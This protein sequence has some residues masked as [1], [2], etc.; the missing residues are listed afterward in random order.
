M[1][2]NAATACRTSGAQR[3]DRLPPTPGKQRSFVAQTCNDLV[4]RQR[5]VDLS[6]RGVEILDFDE[7]ALRGSIAKL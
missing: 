1:N 4:G 3:D 7:R 2:E 5:Q 6:R